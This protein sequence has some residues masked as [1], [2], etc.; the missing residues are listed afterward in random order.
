MRMK[1]KYFPRK[2]LRRV[3]FS[4]SI[5]GKVEGGLRFHTEG[6]LLLL[7]FPYSCITGG[8]TE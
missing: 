3:L 2:W 8:H 4:H 6:F 1:G 7:L 5:Q